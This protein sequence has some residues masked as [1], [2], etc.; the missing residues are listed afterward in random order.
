MSAQQSR[1]FSPAAGGL[2]DGPSPFAPLETWIA[3]REELRGMP[4]SEDRDFVLRW[5][6]RLI[7]KK[8]EAEKSCAAKAK[9][10][11]LPPGP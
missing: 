3:F 11:E 5:A 2:I 1:D 10:R 4:K 8:Q 6:N 7:R 9:G